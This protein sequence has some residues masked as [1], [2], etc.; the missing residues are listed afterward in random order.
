[1]VSSKKKRGQ[2]RKAAQNNQDACL[3]NDATRGA[4]PC[5]SCG[6]N[7]T[8][9]CTTC[10]FN[11]T[12]PIETN[13]AFYQNFRKHVQ[14]GSEYHTRHII[15]M[16]GFLYE[17]SGIL[18]IVLDFLKR[19]ENEMFL[20]VIRRKGK[21]DKL[22]HTTSGDLSS[23]ELWITI[24]LNADANEPSCRLEIAN[25]IGPLM[26]SMCNDT[27]RLFFK[28]NKY[29]IESIGSFACLIWHLIY[30]AADRKWGDFSCPP[31]P[32]NK[33]LEALIQHEGF[34]RSIVQ[35]GFW[36]KEHRPDLFKLNIEGFCSQIANWGNEA[37]LLLADYAANEGNVR[38]LETI[39][40]TPIVSRDY[41]PTCM[42]SC[43]EGLLRLM[44]TSVD[45]NN[46]NWI[47][48]HILAIEK[49]IIDAGC[50]D[51]GVISELMDYGLNYAKDYKTA[52]SVSEIAA[53]MLQSNGQP[54]DTRI[55]FAIRAGIIE[56]CLHFIERF[57]GVQ[58]FMEDFSVKKI[59]MSVHMI[60]LHEKAAKAIRSKRN[61]FLL[62][63]LTLTTIIPAYNID[64]CKELI[65][66]IRSILFL[67]GTYCCR[68]NKSL[69][70]KEIKWCDGCNHMTYCSKACQ[71][72]DWFNDGH[73]L[74]CNVK[75]SYEL[76]GLFQGNL[77]NFQ[78]SLLPNENERYAAKL[79]KLETNITMIQLNLFR[80]YS[81]FILSQSTSPDIHLCDCV[82]I[83][84]LRDC[85]PTVKIEGYPEF[86]FGEEI[87]AFEGSRSKDNI[88]CVYYSHFFNGDR[89][90]ELIQ[91]QRI[92]PSWW[93]GMEESNDINEQLQGI[94]N[95][96]P[97]ESDISLSSILGIPD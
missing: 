57:G 92:F 71:K 95:N 94:F 43:V 6:G 91:M 25:S 60:L 50:V 97:A 76:A 49:L 56:M 30:E 53:S 36:D 5:S 83:F 72:N 1:M 93:L 11:R 64:N 16:S 3:T 90:V 84:D 52:Q 8:T 23:P 22:T 41:D 69:S 59:L 77:C 63:R 44:K 74:S 66:M 28:S 61:R 34:L 81:S 82:V 78:G 47:K 24:L 87:I 38:A 40:S 86:Y 45:R 31:N 88:T 70:R 17:E 32:K 58:S 35:W 65:E 19:C 9:L 33:I 89:G 37:T 62:L 85:P 55:A 73:N 20:R 4:P 79:E 26:K 75:Y 12:I 42:V 14:N 51:K 2:Q 67:H 15:N 29:W 10:G 27:E 54:S 46:A 7:P 13:V 68:C 21:Q 96:M 39:A 48:H 80:H 18:S